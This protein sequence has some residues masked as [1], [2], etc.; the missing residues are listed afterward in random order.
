MR[1]K[2]LDAYLQELT[3]SKRLE[4]VEQTKLELKHKEELLYFFDKEDEIEVEI[5]KKEI[6]RKKREYIEKIEISEDDYIPP[7]T[8]K[9]QSR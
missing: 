4:E 8:Q 1:E 7:E 3:K 2:R 6:L 9:R 5:E